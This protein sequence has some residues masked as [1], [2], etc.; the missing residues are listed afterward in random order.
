MDARALRTT[1]VVFL[2]ALLVHGA[3]HARRGIEIPS[4]ISIVGGLQFALGVFAVTLVLREHRL[5]PVAAVAVG[6][7]SA[8]LFVSA[9]LLPGG[10]DPYTGSSPAAGVTAFSWFTAVFE[11]A[12][13]IAFGVAGAVLLRRRSP[14]TAR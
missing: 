10:N 14:G 7:P 11:I 12:A 1:A 9:H 3:D 13:D 8:L 6:F 2:S 5:G 4:T